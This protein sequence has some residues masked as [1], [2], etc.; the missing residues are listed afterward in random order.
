MRW[1]PQQPLT[2][3]RHCPMQAMHR[4]Q[5]IVRSFRDS[6]GRELQHYMLQRMACSA[7]AE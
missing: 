3:L 5:G 4:S 7:A 6:F 2:C 1:A